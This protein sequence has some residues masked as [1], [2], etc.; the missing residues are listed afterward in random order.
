MQPVACTG[1][2]GAALG[3]PNALDWWFPFRDPPSAV[4]RCVQ[5]VFCFPGEAVASHVCHSRLVWGGKPVLRQDRRLHIFVLLPSTLRDTTKHTSSPKNSSPLISRWWRVMV[6]AACSTMSKPN[7]GCCC[8]SEPA[9]ERQS[10]RLDLAY[11]SITAVP[12]WLPL[13][14]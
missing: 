8:C 6:A 11:C 2:A 14:D 5:A 9:S 4:Q 13:L 10:D 7:H 3:S 1:N 12:R